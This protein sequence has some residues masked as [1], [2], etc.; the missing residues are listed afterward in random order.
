MVTL[1]C[2]TF[3]KVDYFYIKFVIDRFLEYIIPPKLKVRGVTAICFPCSKFLT[4][5]GAFRTSGTYL[6]FILIV[7]KSHLVFITIVSNSLT[8]EIMLSTS[9]GK[10]F[11]I[12]MLRQI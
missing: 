3:I 10:H 12:T 7:R 4:L 1:L 6:R 11:I 8:T 5:D 2:A 9:L